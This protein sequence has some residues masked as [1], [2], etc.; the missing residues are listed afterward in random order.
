MSKA[1][2]VFLLADAGNYIQEDYDQGMTVLT[3][4][5]GIKIE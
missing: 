4:C 1:G 2:L 5:D 3:V